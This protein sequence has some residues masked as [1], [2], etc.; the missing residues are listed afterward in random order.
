MGNIGL[1]VVLRSKDYRKFIDVVVFICICLLS[2]IFNINMFV[3]QENMFFFEVEKE[4]YVLKFMNC[5]GYW[6][7]FGL[8]VC[9]NYSVRCF[10]FKD[11]YY[12]GLC[13]LKEY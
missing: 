11:L 1:L 10:C 3:F 5:L 12:L 2:G 6:Y 8:F 9:Y 4:R 13:W 7:V